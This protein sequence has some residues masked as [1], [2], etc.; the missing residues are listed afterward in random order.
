MC[1]F[2]RH[3]FFLY[4]F[5]FSYIIVF[6][7][8]K[9]RR[10]LA[11]TTAHV[12]S[13]CLMVSCETTNKVM[14]RVFYAFD[15]SLFNKTSD[16]ILFTHASEFFS[17]A[18]FVCPKCGRKHDASFISPYSRYL[19]S[20]DSAS[21]ILNHSID[22]KQ[23]QCTS[24][25]SIHAILPDCL[26]P[27]SSYSLSFILSVL[28]AYYF[29]SCSVETLCNAFFIAISTLYA[30]IKL[31]HR[32]KRLWLGLLRDAEISSTDFIDQVL[33]SDFLAEQ[34][35]HSFAFSFLQY[36]FTTPFNSS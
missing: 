25:G 33:S 24:C 34:F 30:W 4:Y 12:S 7:T 15:K 26:I 23:V 11:P 31:F 14:I 17:L 5:I 22:V 28:R 36:A 20:L 10:N 32:H 21:S 35:V 2:L 16:L 19:I 8:Q 9:K 13:L 18:D 1:C 27:H 29:R 3:I 6:V